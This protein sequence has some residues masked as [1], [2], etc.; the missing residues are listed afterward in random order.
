MHE[1]LSA[2]VTGRVQG[3]G[4]RY[5]TMGRARGLGLVGW[6]RNEHDGAVQIV[7]E[8]PRV[9]LEQLLESVRSGPAGAHVAGVSYD[10]KEATGDFDGF[11][12]RY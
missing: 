12:V 6:V 9:A 5:F 2:R 7:A 4:F 8:G 11:G 10:W 3:V 1:R